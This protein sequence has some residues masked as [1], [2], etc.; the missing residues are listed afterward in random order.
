MG[1]MMTSIE[2]DAL[3]PW[4]RALSRTQWKPLLAS[5]IGWVCDGFETYALILTI[6]VALRQ[7][8][9]PSQYSQIPIYAGSVIALTLVG[10]AVG[11]IIGGILTDYFG[12]KR[13]MLISILTYSFTTGLSAIA[14]D[15]TSFAALRFIA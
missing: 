6:G 15:W 1:S 13:I 12:R 14:W 4:Y 5:N 3:M 7:L 2:S 10:W 11:G 8:L 9:D